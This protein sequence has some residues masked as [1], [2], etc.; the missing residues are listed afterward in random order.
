MLEKTTARGKMQKTD[1]GL[2]DTRILVA[3]GAW[4]EREGKGGEKRGK[5]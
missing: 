5:V 4:R 2:E 3:R 1:F